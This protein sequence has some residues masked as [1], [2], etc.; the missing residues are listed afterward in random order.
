MTYVIYHLLH[1][2]NW[3]HVIDTVLQLYIIVDL[4][5]KLKSMSVRLEV[6]I[7]SFTSKS[8]YCSKG[9]P[10]KGKSEL[11]FYLSHD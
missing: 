5:I 8:W 3:C 1:K 11:C 9:A 10:Q 2:Y 6:N 4:G 7:A